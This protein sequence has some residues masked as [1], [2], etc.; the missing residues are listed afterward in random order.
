MSIIITAEDVLKIASAQIGYKEKTSNA[1]LDNPTLNAGSGNY[2]KF[3]RDLANAGYYNG[4]KNGYAWCDVFVDWCFYQAA[5]KNRTVAEAV[6][7]Q[8]G[9][10]GAGC[11][12]SAQYYKNAGRWSNTPMV[13][14]QIFFSY[15]YGEVS[16][17][18]IVESFDNN[19]V[20]TIEG[21]TSD[22]V[23]RRV[24]KI[25]DSCIYGYGIP[26]YGVSFNGE[27]AIN[28]DNSTVNMPATITIQPTQNIPTTSMCSVSLPILKIGSIGNVVEVAQYLLKKN[29]YSLGVYGIDGDFGGSTLNAVKQFQQANGLLVD[30]E[31]GKDTWGKL[32]GVS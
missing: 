6:E 24:Y 30:G 12:Y 26:K 4:N 14:S 9:S 21:N 19:T 5:G 18:G 13:G 22:M 29:G 20:T 10:C 7:C 27:P 17:T 3:A 16:H 15:A 1:N 31:I 32:L 25:H 11:L 2:T 8:T 28:T 23:A